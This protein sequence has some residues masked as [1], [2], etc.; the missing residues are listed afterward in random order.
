MPKRA[1]LTKELCKRATYEGSGRAP[2]ILWDAE[3]PG[4]GL[5]IHPSGVKGWVVD[6]TLEGKRRRISLGLYGALTLDEAR[7]AAHGA[8]GTARE[9][10]DPDPK[11]AGRN[12]ASPAL[13]AAVCQEYREQHAAKKKSKAE[14]ERRLDKHLVPRW[15]DRPAVEITGRDVLE[16]HRELAEKRPDPARKGRTVGGPY[17][18]NRVLALVSVIF[19]KARDWHLIPEGHP[20]PARGIEPFREQARRRYLTPEEF[21][22][23]AAAIN[24]AALPRRRKGELVPDPHLRALLWLYLLTGLRKS[25]LLERQWSEVDDTFAV[26]RIPDTKGGAP[27]EIPLSP[28]ALE[29]LKTLPRSG[30]YL[31]PSARAAHWKDPRKRWTKILAA[32]GISDLRLHDLRRTLGSWMAHGGANLKLIQEVLRHKDLT[33]TAEHYSHLAQSH[34]RVALDEHGEKLRGLIKGEG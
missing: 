25:E 11:A 34:V 28:P 13:W 1:R 21:P 30:P 18:A 4:L 23:L 29:I 33:T 10:N 17:E 16:L 5:R 12:G 2:R 14:D 32:A 24:A 19:E 31:F 26:L 27:A 6:Y 20:N 8:L 22:R 9:G 7:A 15:R 3:V